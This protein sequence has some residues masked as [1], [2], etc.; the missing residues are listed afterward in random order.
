MPTPASA[1]TSSTSRSETRSPTSSSPA[2]RIGFN[3]EW[4]D[5]TPGN[6]AARNDTIENGTIDASGWTKSRDTV[7]VFLDQGTGS[8]TIKGVTFNNQSWAAIGEYLN[9]GTN[10]VSGNTY[11]LLPGAVAV[12]PG[13][14]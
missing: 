9:S 10:T 13:H 14:M 3:A 12:S 1:S 7:G 11:Q 5:G 6:E 2:R 8:T 4:N